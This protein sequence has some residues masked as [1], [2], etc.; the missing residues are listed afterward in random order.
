MATSY[1]SES[2]GLNNYYSTANNERNTKTEVD[3]TDANVEP[4]S[5]LSAEALKQLKENNKELLERV[6][7]LDDNYKR[8]LADGENTRARM[9]RQVEETKIYAIQNFCKDL[10]DI[11][12]T[13]DKAVNSVPMESLKE[14]DHLSKLH[15]G[16]IITNQQLQSVFRRHGLTVINPVGTKFNPNE[17]QAMFE[18]ETKDKEPGTVAEVL[19]IGYRL[20]D[21]TIRPAH[22]AV[23]KTNN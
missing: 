19:K 7:Q 20:H 16:V 9:F 22:V 1:F 18:V 4:P 5:E 3:A 11:A 6:K 2:Y 15:Q 21:R 10:L 8:A 14:N 12:D 23:V 13:L 17:Q